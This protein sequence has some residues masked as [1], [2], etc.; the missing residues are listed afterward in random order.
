MGVNTRIGKVAA[1]TYSAAAAATTLRGTDP[2]YGVN[3]DWFYPVVLRGEYFRINEPITKVGQ[4]N[5]LTVYVDLTYQY[6]CENRR[7]AGFLVNLH[8]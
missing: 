3:H 2:I 4:H 5:V 7:M 6:I 1:A 8:A